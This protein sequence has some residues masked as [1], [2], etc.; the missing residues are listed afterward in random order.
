M[1]DIQLWHNGK[2]WAE[3]DYIHGVNTFEVLEFFSDALEAIEGPGD[4]FTMI[5][6]KVS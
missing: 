1:I 6:N 3:F 5:V 4:G 2:L